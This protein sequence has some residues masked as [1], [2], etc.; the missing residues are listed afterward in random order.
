LSL[1]EEHGSSLRKRGTG[2][3]STMLKRSVRHYVRM[4]TNTVQE[5]ADK[6]KKQNKQKY[7]GLVNLRK[8]DPIGR[9]MSKQKGRRAVPSTESLEANNPE[10][11][12]Q[13][14]GGSGKNKR[15]QAQVLELC[16]DG[17][18]EVTNHCVGW[19]GGERSV[20]VG[21]GRGPRG[22]TEMPASLGKKFQTTEEGC[23]RSGVKICTWN[24]GKIVCRPPGDRGKVGTKGLPEVRGVTNRATSGKRNQEGRA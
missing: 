20:L 10:G 14:L 2:K 11:P 13:R 19:G 4:R 7:E 3:P 8:K 21:K 1:P 9:R 16:G 22:G 12:E 15:N 18:A 5:D 17:E 24:L 23:R 6:S